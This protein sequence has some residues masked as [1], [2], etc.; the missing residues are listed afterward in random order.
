[1]GAHTKPWQWFGDFRIVHLG[2]L[3]PK[4]LV[5][6]TERREGD[7]SL[8]LALDREPASPSSGPDLLSLVPL[9]FTLPLSEKSILMLFSA[10]HGKARDE[11]RQIA[12]CLPLNSTSQKSKQCCQHPSPV[13]ESTGG[14][15]ARLGR[16]MALLLPK[17]QLQ[18]MLLL[19]N[20]NQNI[21]MAE[22]RA[23]G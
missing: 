17:S 20:L 9:F 1:M 19:R 18:G 14:P 22:H 5:H 3:N 10:F 16:R 21:L 8:L 7:E 23:R 4:S 2:I 12:S 13:S 6:G 11:D 15:R